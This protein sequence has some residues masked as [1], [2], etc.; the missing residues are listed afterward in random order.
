MRITR[1]FAGVAALIALLGSA[2]TA[3]KI[4]RLTV[5][6][7]SP[8]GYFDY[9]NYLGACTTRLVCPGFGPGRFTRFVFTYDTG[10]ISQLGGVELLSARMDL[11]RSSVRF[12]TGGT[13]LGSFDFP[14]QH[15][16]SQ[17]TGEEATIQ[18]VSDNSYYPL[19][20]R[21]PA[22]NSYYISGYTAYATGLHGMSPHDPNL[23]TIGGV[24]YPNVFK[25]N[26]FRISLFDPESSGLNQPF[27]HIYDPYLDENFN[28]IQFANLYAAD[29]A[30][31]DGSFSHLVY[32]LNTS[33][34]M[35]TTDVLNQTGATYVHSIQLEDVTPGGVP[36]P[37]TWAL[38]LLGFGGIGAALRRRIVGRD[39]PALPGGNLATRS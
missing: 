1:V 28:N 16:T 24:M 19:L 11:F 25:I 9:N 13:L 10:V 14:L 17:S 12:D 36:E 26:T 22:G 3:A 29:S 4:M 35:Y 33:G 38:M 21:P 6:G 34:G 23:D 2:G 5:V 31:G 20:S 27:Y 15:T 39:A 18:A 32:S 8:I 30:D 7:T 37:A